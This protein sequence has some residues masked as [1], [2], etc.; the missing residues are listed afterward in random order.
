MKKSCKGCKHYIACKGTL[1]ACRYFSKLDIKS[2]SL[3]FRTR[4]IDTNDEYEIRIDT[5]FVAFPGL[6]KVGQR[7]EVFYKKKGVKYGKSYEIGTAIIS[8]G[9]FKIINW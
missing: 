3:D 9:V 4:D 5:V 7:L 1:K 6:T 8:K 2:M